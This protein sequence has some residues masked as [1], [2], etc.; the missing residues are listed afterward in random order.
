VRNVLELLIAGILEGGV[1]LAADL[2]EGVIGDADAAGLGDPLQPRGDVDAIAEDVAFLDDDVADVNPDAQLDAPVGGLAGIALCHSA[3]LRDSA[4]GGVHGAAELDQNAV[5]GPLDDPAAVL[6]NR[7]LQQ[8]AAMGVEPGERPFLVGPHQPAVADNI[9]G[10]NGSKPPLHTMFGHGASAP[11]TDAGRV[12][13][14]RL[15]VSMQR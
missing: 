10:E 4:A 14:W 1:D 3:L 13:G 7:R 6:C 2:P 12:Y 11:H 9:P 8:F 15:R 5:A